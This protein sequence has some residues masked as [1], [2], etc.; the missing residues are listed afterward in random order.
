MPMLTLYLIWSC[1]WLGDLAGAAQLADEATDTA[2]LLGDA[3]AAAIALAAQALV[4]TYDGSAE[5]ARQEAR[6]ALDIFERLQWL[7]GTIWPLWA[8]GFVELS[9]GNPAAVDA[10]LG[11]LAGAITAMPGD[12][13]LAVFVPDEIEA[14]VQLGDIERAE[15]FTSWLEQHAD[16]LDRPW[17]RAAACRSRGLIHGAVRDTDAAVAALER[18]RAEYDGLDL[19][20]ERA[21]TLLVLGRVLRRAGRR[22]QARRALAEALAIFE[23]VG[24]PLWVAQAR[25]ALDRLGVRAARV[26]AL[27]P[28]EARLAELAA[29][30]LSNR[31]IAQREFLTVK[32]VEANLTRVYRKLG[33][34]SRT[35]LA[36]DLARAN[37]QSA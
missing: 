21:R 27:S 13:S 18:A 9:C 3:A 14:L 31:E 26:D 35:E 6:A 4:H 5:Q 36:R 23:G 28:T 12:V 37:D 24:A 25:D 15:A 11:P 29:A 32:A 22:A 8:V 2:A 16:D 33:V 17:A 10:V 19:P 20:F 30:G 1:V 7:P 34:R